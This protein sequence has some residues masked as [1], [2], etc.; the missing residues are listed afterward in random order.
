MH[1]SRPSIAACSI[2]NRTVTIIS[3]HIPPNSREKAVLSRLTCG[4]GR[5]EYL[6]PLTGMARHPLADVNCEPPRAIHHPNFTENLFDIRHLILQNKCKRP[7]EGATML[8]HGAQ[9]AQNLFYDLGA[10]NYSGSFDLDTGFGMGPSVPLFMELYKR[11]CIVFDHIWAW[12]YTAFDPR[13]YW[14]AVPA[15]AR[16]KLHFMNIP[17]PVE[18]HPNGFLSLLRA[19]AK[20]QDFVAVKVDVDDSRVEESVVWAIAHDRYLA[21]LVD[22]LF[23]EY[24]FFGE[25]RFILGWGI[26]NNPAFP[27][28]WTNAT[29]ATALDLM[30]KLR[31]RGIRG[32]FWI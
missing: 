7:T 26:R 15:D 24:H 9:S 10:S 4:D 30:R 3:A 16:G 5:H 22:E 32:H 20:P 17:V 29:V 19:T 11:N 2:I 1:I 28:S 18:P 6:E 8:P 14:S 13:Q 12:E 31:E 27:Q 23:F 21:S 25:P